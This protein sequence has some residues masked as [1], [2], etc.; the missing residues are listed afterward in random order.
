MAGIGPYMPFIGIF[1]FVAPVLGRDYLN[2]DSTAI[3]VITDST[4]TSK[5]FALV[6]SGTGYSFSPSAQSS[7]RWQCGNL[8][9][10]QDGQES[11]V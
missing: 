11:Y 4:G 3:K 1:A 9:G 2:G 5:A 7:S 6:L 10:C 8:V